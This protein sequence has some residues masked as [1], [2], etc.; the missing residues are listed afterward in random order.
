MI[1][2]LPV[3]SRLS[4]LPKLD[5]NC[6][7]KT[8]HA[9][10]SGTSDFDSCS[11]D[12]ETFMFCAQWALALNTSTTMMPH[13]YSVLCVVALNI[14][15]FGEQSKHSAAQ[16]TEAELGYPPDERK[17]WYSCL[18]PSP[19]WVDVEI[20]TEFHVAIVTLSAV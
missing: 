4:S 15:M 18:S 14:L 16:D 20:L 13:V 17:M 3:V 7:P 2:T 10:S 19:S 5:H 9:G 6:S 12:D 1:L 8:G 11:L